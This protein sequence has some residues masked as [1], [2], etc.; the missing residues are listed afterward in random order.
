[1]DEGDVVQELGV[2]APVE[3]WTKALNTHLHLACFV[4]QI[5]FAAQLRALVLFHGH[6]FPPKW[7]NTQKSTS[8]TQIWCITDLA[9][10]VCIESILILKNL[11]VAQKITC[12]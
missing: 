3:V 8:A 4:A 1:M 7:Q 10:V 11:H 5:R 6:S 9:N 2:H 12:M